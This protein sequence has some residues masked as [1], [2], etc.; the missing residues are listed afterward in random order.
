MPVKVTCHYRTEKV[1]SFS[2]IEPSAYGILDIL[3]EEGP[4]SLETLCG[5]YTFNHREEPRFHNRFFSAPNPEHSLLHLSKIVY[6]Y[7][8]H[9]LR[10]V[11][12]PLDYVKELIECTT[13]INSLPNL[14]FYN[15]TYFQRL[16]RI[17]SSREI[18]TVPNPI[19]PP[20]EK[21]T[22]VYVFDSKKDIPDYYF[23]RSDTI[24]GKE[25]KK[26]TRSNEPKGSCTRSKSNTD[27]DTTTVGPFKDFPKNEFTTKGYGIQ[28][29]CEYLLE[30]EE[31]Y[32]LYEEVKGTFMFTDRAMK[33]LIGQEW[34]SDFHGKVFTLELIPYT[35]RHGN[36]EE[37]HSLSKLYLSERIR[38]THYNFKDF[39]EPDLTED[40]NTNPVARHT[41][42]TIEGLSLDS[43]EKVETIESDL[44][45]K[46]R[47]KRERVQRTK[48]NTQSNEPKGSR[49]KSRTQKNSRRSS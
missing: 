34:V 5:I 30:E 33:R 13:D 42:Q 14:E 48:V 44:A 27:T 29:V 32:T 25:P 31:E 2:H 16:T 8:G 20:V 35:D 6:Q 18:Y 36:E 11:N 21:I 37:L 4:Q 49:K 17:T 22:K 38:H 43:V 40:T 10:P 15:Q 19:N 47:L 12:L 41:L 45:R 7:T 9:Y 3:K 39:L 24:I 23:G 46:R 26:A 28:D 1:E